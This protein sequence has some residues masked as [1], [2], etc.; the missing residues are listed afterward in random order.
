[1]KWG[2]ELRS[3][4]PPLLPTVFIQLLSISL[5][6]LTV[7]RF[8]QRLFSGGSGTRMG[9]FR[10]PLS[11]KP[12]PVSPKVGRAYLNSE[13]RVKLHTLYHSERNKTV[14]LLYVFPAVLHK[15]WFRY[16][17]TRYSTPVRDR[18]AT[19]NLVTPSQ[20]EQDT[21]NGG[22]LTAKTPGT[23]TRDRENLAD[24]WLTGPQ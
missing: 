10:P 21:H 23:V 14:L 4:I 24:S 15:F 9:G 20:T 2:T 1:M 18:N 19:P 5:T 12:L 8:Y 7:S 22:T 11:L 6:I 16:K 17:A 13:S 3:I